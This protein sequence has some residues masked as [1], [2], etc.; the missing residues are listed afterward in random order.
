MSEP[1]TREKL[2]KAIADAGGTWLP[3]DEEK[4]QVRM[5]DGFVDSLTRFRKEY[6]SRFGEMPDPFLLLEKDRQKGKAFFQFDT[7]G[8]ST[9]IKVMVWRILLGCEIK[10]IHFDYDFVGKAELK[11]WLQTPSG[12]EEGPYTG[13][14]CEDFRVMR[15]FGI[16]LYNERFVI[17]GYYAFH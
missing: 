11:F 4:F 9:E 14:P 16:A 12:E 17:Q 2:R 8:T 10:R 1:I 5:L 13:D 6:S 15:H 3:D 7:L